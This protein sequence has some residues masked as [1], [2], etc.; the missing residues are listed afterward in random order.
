MTDGLEPRLLKGLQA[1]YVRVVYS[2]ANP[3]GLSIHGKNILVKPDPCSPRSPGGVELPPDLIERMTDASVTGAIFGVGP[4]AFRLFDD[5]TPWK[6]PAPQ[7]GDRIV[8]EKY[9]GVVVMGTDGERY[10]IIDY[11][12]VAATIDQAAEEAA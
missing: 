1:T 8:F 11:R 5:G 9:A 4:E 7:L 10:R 6:G 3:S 12:A 2:G